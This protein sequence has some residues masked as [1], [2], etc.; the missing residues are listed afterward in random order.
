MKIFI[1]GATGFIGTAL[2]QRLAQD[3]FSITALIRSSQKAKLLPA[4]IQIIHG[5]PM[6]KG[7]WQNVVAEQDVIVNLTGHNIFTRWTKHAKKLIH[8]TRVNST[9]NIVDAIPEGSN[10]TLINATASGFYGFTGDDECTEATPPGKDF[11]ATVC[12]DWEFEASKAAGK[13]RVVLTRFGVVLGKNGGALAKML[14]GFKS[15]AAGRLGH[16]RQWFPWIH[17]DDLI[18]ALTFIMR[19][20]DIS[21]PVNCCAPN[22]IRNLEFTKAL[23][24]VLHRPTVIPAPAFLVRLAL[25]ELSSVVLEGCRVQP[26]VLLKK[27]FHF[28]FDNIEDALKDL[29]YNG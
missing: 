23:G 9:K 10:I 16:G 12:K 2:C 8:D 3:G 14:P 25:G 24:K 21:G 5:S 27:G 28:G 19:H 29:L 22:Q 1:A 17:I 18:N 7:D 11:L 13:A 6:D 20:Q 15:G 26:E 4:N